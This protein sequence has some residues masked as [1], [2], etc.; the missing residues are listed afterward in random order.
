MPGTPG[1][2][3]VHFV[4]EGSI[5]R[6]GALVTIAMAL[7]N[8]VG[9]EFSVESLPKSLFGASACGYFALGY[10]PDLPQRKPLWPV[11]SC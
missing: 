2:D 5:K 6:F 3:A 10:Q 7:G 8:L 1:F 4:L 9:G 11:L